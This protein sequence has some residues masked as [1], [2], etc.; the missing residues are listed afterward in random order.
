M[1][2]LNISCFVPSHYDYLATTLIQGLLSLGHNCLGLE[3]SNYVRKVSKKEMR[4]FARKCDI[5]IV[6]S[7]SEGHNVLI[8]VESLV[9]K[10]YVDGSDFPY[11]KAPKIAFDYFFK[12]E[13]LRCVENKAYPLQ[14]GVKNH[15]V[16]RQ[17]FDFK[18][19][20]S[21]V[22]AMSNYTRLSVEKYLCSR[23]EPDI[24]VGGTN[25]RAYDGKSGYPLKTPH[26]S[27][28]LNRSLAS[29]DVP[30]LGWDCGRTW[31]ILGSGA[32]LIQVRSELL[33]CEK[34]T[35]D[36]HFIGFS[37]L[38]ELAA[39]LDEIRQRPQKYLEIRKAG[40]IHALRKHSSKAR[41]NY[42]LDII[43]KNIP[44]SFVGTEEL[45][46]DIK[47]FSLKKVKKFLT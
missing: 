40:Y 17:N 19:L 15:Y 38:E 26:Y 12:R 31:E 41:A 10:V 30:G 7:G 46:R 4:I 21:F 33:Y 27:D 16:Q 13:L 8:E 25:E 11:V 5:I 42:F 3:D 34:L 22:G 2:Q 28:I 23:A 45:V 47:G 1:M 37:N 9:T 18:W 44:N 20:V 43:E 29:I 35:E 39:I 24:F 6:F 14:F 36:E 32:L